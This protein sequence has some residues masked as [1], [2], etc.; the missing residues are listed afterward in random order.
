MLPSPAME[1][2]EVAVP[3]RVEVLSDTV[4]KYLRRGARA[5]LSRLL[6]RVRPEDVAMLLRGL[7]AG[8]QFELFQILVVEYPESA[9]HVLTEL[10]APQRRELIAK[11]SPEEIA[12]V[13]EHTA[14]DDAV[15]LVESL[16]PELHDR[17]LEIADKRDISTVQTHLTYLRDTAGRIMDPE[18]F[19]LPKTT[20]TRDAIAALQEAKDVEM[21]F[22]LYVV[23]LDGQLA[24]VTS[25]RQLLVS[26]P[27][28]TLAEIMNRSVIQVHTDTDQE[29]VAQLAARYDLLA[30]PVTDSENKLVGIVTVDDIID[31]VKEEATEDVYKMVGSSDTELLYENRPF[32]VAQIRLPALLVNLAGLLA[33]GLLLKY[34]QMSMLE[35]LFLLTFVPVVM[36]VSGNI[37]SQTAAI[38]ARALQPGREGRLRQ[39]L[40]QQVLIAAILGLVCSL[41][42]AAVALLLERNVYYALVV[43][44][45]LFLSV[46]VAALNGAAT[47]VLF[48]RL[49]ID[50]VISAG[51]L[52]TT[53]NDIIGILVFYGLA[54]A[55]IEF[56]VR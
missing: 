17:V 45:A 55:L 20:T 9:G 24:G 16:P 34:F 2:T 10:E 35:A 25:L 41:V 5:N 4:R 37:G 38:A 43:G 6:S 14:V 21:I 30:I 31:I 33:S 50:P 13:L 49:G 23:D 47:P 44:V 19:A 39:F 42:V 22:Y 3:R 32:R 40:V 29:E 15:F 11:L 48:R 46:L 18:F 8:E 36:G 27:G 26:P 56:L 12:A 54:S 1:S 52:V 51:P 7:A 28:R 53:S